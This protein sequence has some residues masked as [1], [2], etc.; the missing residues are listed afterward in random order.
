MELELTSNC[1]LARLLAVNP[2]LI[3]VTSASLLLSVQ[4]SP[5]TVLQGP[6]SPSNGAHSPRWEELNLIPA[7][8]S[9]AISDCPLPL[10]ST[11][12]IH[13]KPMLSLLAFN[14]L[15]PG[16]STCLKMVVHPCHLKIPG[17]PSRQPRGKSLA[18][19]TL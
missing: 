6:R 1:F 19:F 11:H 17:P 5:F 8:L 3:P 15:C 12:M 10:A 13:V 7:G 4:C 14:N 16:H 9:Y 2:S 18:A